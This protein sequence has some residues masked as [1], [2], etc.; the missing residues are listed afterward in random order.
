[1]DINLKNLL[2][3]QKVNYIIKY[4]IIDFNIHLILLLIFLI[5]TILLRKK[6]KKKKK[7]EDIN[8]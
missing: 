4:I 1:M 2:V 3:I 6:K 8:N 7:E 5:L